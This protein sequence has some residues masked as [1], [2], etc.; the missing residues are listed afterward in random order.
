MESESDRNVNIDVS[1]LTLDDKDEID[2][3]KVTA[4][5]LPDAPTN[6][7][8]QELRKSP[9]EPVLSTEDDEAQGESSHI[10]AAQ[11]PS[12]EIYAGEPDQVTFAHRRDDLETVG[13]GLEM[14]DDVKD[15]RVATEFRWR[16]GGNEVYLTG[17]FDDWKVSIPMRR[18]DNIDHEF[19]AAVLLDRSQRYLFKFVVDGSWH[20]S[21]EWVAEPDWRGNW[22]NVLPVINN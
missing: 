19:T 4:Q 18:D 20:C 21:G 5:E 16:H 6:L 13:H 1:P 8:S 14:K 7:A 15:V 2:I 22:N 12:E 17:T 10:V 9:D 3:S 11:I